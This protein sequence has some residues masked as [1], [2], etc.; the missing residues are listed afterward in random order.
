MSLVIYS[1]I[2]FSDFPPS[3]N[4]NYQDEEVN[5]ALTEAVKSKRGSAVETLLKHL[6]I[7]ENRKRNHG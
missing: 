6:S 5:S 7:D 3:A 2:K 1:K 4:I